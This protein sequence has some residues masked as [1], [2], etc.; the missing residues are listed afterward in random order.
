MGSFVMIGGVLISLFIA[1]NG[2]KLRSYF[3]LIK[4]IVG[5][6]GL[7]IVYC[8]H[9]YSQ[10][11]PLQFTPFVPFIK[12]FSN[13]LAYK[14]YLAIGVAIILAIVIH[15]NYT[16]FGA[17]LGTLLF[18]A[19]LTR[20]LLYY[21]NLPYPLLM[22]VGGAIGLALRI[23]FKERFTLIVSAVGGSIA[24]SLLFKTFYYLPWWLFAILTLLF[25]LIALYIQYRSWQKG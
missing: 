15:H 10:S 23:L 16:T 25:S 12:S 19:L 18:Y 2:Y 9:L 24:A 8:L 22:V 21:F 3:D 6:G 20:V 7:V 4:F 1:F 13:F 14:Y 5:A 17:P 11:S